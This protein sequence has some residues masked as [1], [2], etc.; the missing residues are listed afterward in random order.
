MKDNQIIENLRKAKQDGILTNQQFNTLKGQVLRGRERA[1]AKG[2]MSIMK[3]KK[4]D[5]E[6]VEHN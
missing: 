2:F 6:R 1:A 5:E 4:R 3:A